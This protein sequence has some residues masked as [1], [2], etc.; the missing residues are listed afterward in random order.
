MISLQVLLLEASKYD[1]N[2]LEL[3]NKLEEDINRADR[4]KYICD[5]FDQSKDKI[6]TLLSKNNTFQ[7]DSLVDID[8]RIDW[9][10]KSESIEKISEAKYNLNLKFASGKTKLLQCTQAQLQDLQTKF[11]D[12]F[13]S[14]NSQL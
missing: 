1:Y 12:A 8:W 10:M 6:R 9:V 3:G 7:F 5:S 13:N 14:V 4:V 11:N 2:G